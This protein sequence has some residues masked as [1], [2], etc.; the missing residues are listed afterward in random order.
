MNIPLSDEMNYSMDISADFFSQYI[1]ENEFINTDPKAGTEDYAT[2]LSEIDKLFPD[3]YGLTANKESALDEI[4]QLFDLARTLGAQRLVLYGTGNFTKELLARLDME[5][6]NNIVAIAEKEGNN[7][8]QLPFKVI[9]GKELKKIDFD[10]VIISSC[11][12]HLAKSIYD[13]LIKYGHTK[14]QILHISA[15][16]GDNIACE[17]P[18]AGKDF[19]AIKSGLSC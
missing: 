8:Y 1:T 14:D 9:K 10:F 16:P 15:L 5:T 11:M 6:K 7:P 3:G 4:S 2:Y 13:D 19:A 18:S 17:G 12:P